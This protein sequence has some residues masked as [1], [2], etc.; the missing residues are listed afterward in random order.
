MRFR[1]TLLLLLVL[2]GLGAY[3]YW[4]E[5]PEAEKADRKE[6][7]LDFEADRVDSITLVFP[8]REIALAKTDAGWRLVRPIEA[9]A[10]EVAVKGVLSMLQSAEVTQELDVDRGDLAPF[11]LAEPYAAVRL[12]ADGNELPEVRIGKAAPIGAAAYAVREGRDAVLLTGSAVRSGVDKS[13]KDLRGKTIL[14]F[15]DDAVE[16]VSIESPERTLVLERRG[17]DWRIV[18]PVDEAADATVVRSYLATLRALRATDYPDE[19]VDLETYDLA[20]PRLRVTVALAGGAPPEVLLVGGG[21]AKKEVY[22]KTAASPVVYTVGDWAGRDLDKPLDDFRDK[23]LLVFA[24]DDV[25][26]IEVSGRVEAPFALLRGDDGVWSMEGEERPVRQPDAIQYLT[27]VSTLQGHAVVA[28]AVGDL[29]TYGLEPPAFAIRL[30]GES[31]ADLGGILLGKTE[32]EGKAKHVAS[33]SGS[34]RVVEL[35]DYTYARLDRPASDFLEGG[36]GEDDDDGDIDDDDD[37]DDAD[38]EDDGDDEE[39]DDEDDD[40]AGA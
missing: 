13:V 2:L 8:D 35:R 40:A 27:D 1:N 20:E 31:G 7:L 15:E 18:A 22:V 39:E 11:G 25:R 3:V 30:V 5:L 32:V 21:N 24:K 6:K 14:R 34:G 38:D 37:E 17:S 29:A 28:D 16:R 12:V 10:D 4:V 26:R 19:T 23:T 33:R 36:E 9:E